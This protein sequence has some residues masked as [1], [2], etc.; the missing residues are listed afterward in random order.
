MSIR[1]QKLYDCKIIQS[2]DLS[3]MIKMRLDHIKLW[4]Q[5]WSSFKMVKNDHSY[6]H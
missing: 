3:L 4:N 1:E 6:D 5:P 2:D